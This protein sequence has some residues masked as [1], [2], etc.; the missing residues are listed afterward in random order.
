[1]RA[2][3]VVSP[4]GHVFVGDI[5]HLNLLPL[6]HSSVQL[7]RA[8]EGLSIRQLKERTA[9]AL[10]Q[11]KELVLDPELFLALPTHLQRIGD[12]EI[13][14][15]R[16]CS[17]NELTRFRYDVELHVGDVTFS[18]QELL[19]WEPG[20]SSPGDLASDVLGARRPPGL[21]ICR[22][23]NRRL[24]RSLA[25]LRQIETLDERHDVE[26]VRGAVKNG[27]EAAAEDPETFWKLGETYGYSV[28]VSPTRGACD[29]SF[30]VLLTDASR[31]SSGHVLA[32]RQPLIPASL[33][34]YANNP[35]EARLTQSLG[36]DLREVLKRHLPDYMV[37]A[38]FVILDALPLTPNGKLDRQA[39]PAPDESAVVRRGHEAPEGEV[40]VAIAQIWQELLGVERVGRQD[41]VFELGGRS[42]LA[43]DVVARGGGGGGRE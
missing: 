6:F 15:M 27:D 26:A 32:F 20:G 29:G 13:L 42:L 39:L 17:V 24:A 23:P 7:A 14:R 9:H 18:D 5:R 22:V 35:V 4:G 31:L 8:P 16:G 25:Q 40:E 38:A 41:Q 2:V 37:P 34:T 10:S 28:R 11:E 36:V 3:A 30:D 21:G 43:V 12:V 19:E 1:E 33:N